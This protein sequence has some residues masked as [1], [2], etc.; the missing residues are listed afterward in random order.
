MERA[1]Y[2]FLEKDRPSPRGCGPGI[3]GNGMELA[4]PE[5][6]TMKAYGGRVAQIIRGK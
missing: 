6:N 5:T 3:G 1:G 2:S 4:I